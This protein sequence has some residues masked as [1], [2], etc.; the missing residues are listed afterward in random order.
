MKD[1]LDATVVIIDDDKRIKDEPLFTELKIAFKNIQFFD[2]P[3]IGIEY[4]KKNL[5]QRM[6]VLLDLAFPTNHSDGHK[7]LEL[8]RELS[9]LIPVIIWSAKDED[10]ETFA[11]LI[12]NHSFAF[13]KKTA[14][15][16]EI[17]KK[18][19]EALDSR[20]NDVSI[21]LEEWIN[22]HSS[23]QKKKPYMYTLDGKEYS[24]NDILH[25][26]RL[27]SNIGR[28]FAKNITKLTIDLLTRNKEALDD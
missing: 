21:A 28:Y 15:S 3:N 24:L 8:I 12:N 5:A 7:I 25:E 23:E 26:V 1:K 19:E 6:V 18:I 11:D 9:D 20:Q 27:Q 22:A 16:E 4:I 13:L 2:V 17:V 14:S 10:K